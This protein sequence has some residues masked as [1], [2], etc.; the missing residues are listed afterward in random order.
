MGFTSITILS[1]PSRMRV[2]G[3]AR[4]GFEQDGELDIG[5]ERFIRYRRF[6]P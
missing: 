3:V 1:P 6:T 4:L 2:R 5:G